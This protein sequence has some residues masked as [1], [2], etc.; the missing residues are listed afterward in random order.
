M[1]TEP[2]RENGISVRYLA[3]TIINDVGM[4]NSSGIDMFIDSL[5]NH[6]DVSKKL[7]SNLNYYFFLHLEDYGIDDKS[8]IDFILWNE[9][10]IL[11]V[12][13]KAF[14]DANS[15]DVKKEIIRNYL[16]VDELKKE[17]MFHFNDKQKIFPVLLYSDSYQ[18]WKRGTN[19][20]VNYFNKDFLLTKGKNQ[21]QLLDNWG[22]GDYPIPSKYYKDPDFI[23]NVDLINKRLFFST[24]EN[25]YDIH[26]ELNNHGIF[27]KKIEELKYLKDLEQDVKG[28]HLVNSNGAKISKT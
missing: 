17:S 15:P 28:I 5:V 18:N 25:V 14:T 27:S 23:K 20:N 6:H 9:N 22:R 3:Q 19:S 11:P 24:W 13:V 21:D 8:E 26:I 12:E 16:H 10:V 2:R 4:C 7:F 1:K